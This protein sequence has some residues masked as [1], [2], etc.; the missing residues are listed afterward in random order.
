MNIYY[1]VQVDC[2][3]TGLVI[4][5]LLYI[6]IA[7]QSASSWVHDWWKA[8]MLVWLLNYCLKATVFVR[9]HAFLT[10]F[11]SCF[12]ELGSLWF[13]V[14]N[15]TDSDARHLWKADCKIALLAAN[16][17]KRTRFG[18]LTNKTNFATWQVWNK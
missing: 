18:A 13:S 6:I 9:K 10:A 7:T 17:K 14:R 15:V 1:N 2:D 3:H 5:C 16:M 4:S 12:I 11:G 8:W